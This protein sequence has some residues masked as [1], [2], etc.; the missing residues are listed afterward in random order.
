M[1]PQHATLEAPARPEP[2]AAEERKTDRIEEDLTTSIRRHARYDLALPDG[3]RTSREL[4]EA[5]ARAVRDRAVERW[6]ET[7]VRYAAADAKRL[8][9]LSMEFL[10]GRSLENNLQNLGL[11]ADA[12]QAVAELGGDLEAVLGVEHDAALGN[13]GLGRLAACFLDSLASLDMPG[14]GYGIHYEYG[15]FRQEI[16]NGRQREHP[17]NWLAYGSPWEIERPGEACV[18]PVYGSIEHTTDAAGNYNPLWLGWKVLVGVPYDFP[19]VGYGGKTVNW[20]RL[21]S[22][23]SSDEFDM[24]IF[25]EGDYLRAVEQKMEN[26]TIS[27]VLYPSDAVA[28]GRELR[29]LQEYFLV[30]CAVR[31]LVRRFDRRADANPAE[32][33]RF[34]AI[35]LNDTHPTLAVLELMRILIDEKQLSWEEAWPVVTATCG[36]TNHTL[37]PEALERWPVPLFE[38]LLPRHLQLLYEINRRFLAEV[39]AR[40]PGDDARLGRMSIIEEGE[41]K[42]ARMAY[43]AIVG[44]HSVNGVAALHSEL[45]KT[46]LVPDFH[47]LWPEKFNNKTNG[48]TPRRWLLSANP[49]L[50][51]LLDEAVG[52]GWAADLDRLRK[53]EILADDP[54]F[55]DSFAKIKRQNKERLAKT[56]AETARVKVDPASLF[57]IQVKRI[58]EYKRQLLNALHIAHQ[59]LALVEDGET[60][61]VPKTYVFA[62]KAAP[63]YWEAKQIILLINALATTINRDPRAR[64][65]LRVAFVP[66]YRVSTAEII[67][68][69]GEISE[70]IST[71]GTEASGTSNMKFAMNGALTLGTLDGANVEISEKVG[72]E[73]AYIFGLTTDEVAAVKAGGYRPA[74]YYG[75]DPA[76][77]RVI[78]AV[79]GDR[80]SP[81]AP[82]T[83]SWVWSSLVDGGD[84]YLLLAD[85]AAYREVQARAATDY[86]DGAAWWRKAI[87]NVARSG[88]FSSDRTIREYADQIWG[89][90][91]VRP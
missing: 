72:L 85:F 48:V 32:L 29:L 64:D 47:A 89:L 57:D 43:L 9:Y 81:G 28:S 86:R 17:D 79:A 58:H 46:S 38:R 62:G 70:Q 68:P 20:L 6:L 51:R 90:S 31:D 56:I 73:N 78:D 74:A 60:P 83:F 54:G 80:F 25:N 22:A 15:L 34:V 2:T 26:E 67:I 75:N 53:L 18:I 82:G 7:E 77:K 19:I 55:Q 88:H 91:S 87:L 61:P 39:A 50:A 37:M 40:F 65:W 52:T 42:Q 59:Y 30:A 1:V 3:P 24:E 12:R 69:A 44:S 76:L 5:I 71:A 45:V 41:P 49:R 23:R 84:P 63:G 4:L 10:V 11:L 35:Q 33:A 16:D 66:D 36:Y 13:G 21:F 27:K 8:Y 14:F